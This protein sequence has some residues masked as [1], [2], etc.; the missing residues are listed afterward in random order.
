M[1]CIEV[2][3]MRFGQPRS[4]NLETKWWMADITQPVQYIWG[5][6]QQ[7]DSVIISYKM[8][9]A[10][11]SMQFLTTTADYNLHIPFMY[12]KPMDILRWKRS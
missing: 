8:N 10:N 2:I 6:H 5:I 1:K 7:P 3:K 12:E 9:G 11:V 4:F